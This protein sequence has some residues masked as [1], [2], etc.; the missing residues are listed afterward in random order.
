M[1]STCAA[2]ATS[3]YAGQHFADYQKVDWLLDAAEQSIRQSSETA[4]ELAVE[5]LL[6]DA[7]GAVPDDVDSII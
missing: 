5:A 3:P 1:V 6:I 2:L 4:A 7:V